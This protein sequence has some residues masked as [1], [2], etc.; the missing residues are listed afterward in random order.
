MIFG[1]H[2]KNVNFYI[3]DKE[4]EIVKN[5]KYLGITFTNNRRFIETIK[6]NIAK[7]KRAMYSIISKAK[8]N[9]LSISCQIH[10]FKIT[11]IPIFL[12][13]CEAWG[14]ENLELIEK[15]QLEFCRMILRLNKNTPK[16]V[17]LSETGLLPIH[18]LVK[19][20]L[21]ITGLV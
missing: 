19:V 17:L 8:C 13:G 6:L 15:A 21:L 14:Y 11:V 20:E 3:N 1:K 4:I 7:G 18:I 16:H 2:K 5:F 12:Y 9:G 10:L